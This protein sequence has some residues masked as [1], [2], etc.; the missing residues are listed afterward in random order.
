MA[1][2]PYLRETKVLQRL[3]TLTQERHN[4]YCL[5]SFSVEVKIPHLEDEQNLDPHFVGLQKN[6][7]NIHGAGYQT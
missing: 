5:T 4:L 6:C 2:K 1:V 7:E 3:P